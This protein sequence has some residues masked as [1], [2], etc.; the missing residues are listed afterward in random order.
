MIGEMLA[1]AR[2]FDFSAKFIILDKGSDCLGFALKV[3]ASLLGTGE[4][5]EQVLKQ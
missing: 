2:L 4:I 3:V 1:L 5:L